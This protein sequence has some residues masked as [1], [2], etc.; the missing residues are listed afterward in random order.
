[1]D[2]TGGSRNIRRTCLV[3]LIAGALTVS[4]AVADDTPSRLRRSESFFGLHF[5]LHACESDVEIGKTLTEGMVQRIIDVARPDYLQ[6]DSKGHEGFCSYPTEVG[7]PAGGFVKDPLRIWRDVTVRNGVALYV[8][9]S[10]LADGEAVAQNPDWG[11][12]DADGTLCKKRP[13]FITSYFGPY[14]DELMIPQLKELNDVYGVDGAWVDGECWAAYHDYS[15]YALKAWKDKTGDAGVPRKSGELHWEE[16][17][18]FCRQG[19]RDYF[20]RYVDAIHAYN[21]DFQIA[22]NWAYS[23]FMPEPVTVGVDFISGD[24]M[25]QNSINSA[26]F[27]GRCLAEQGVAWDLMAWSFRLGARDGYATST[28]TALQLQQEAAMV[29]AL[30]GGFQCYFKQDRFCGIAEWQIQIMGELAAFCRERQEFCHKAELIPQ[31]GLLYSRA[32][33][34]H[35]GNKLFG[36]FKQLQHPAEG[37]LECLLDGQNAVQIVSEHHLADGKISK[38]PV[39]VVPEW[40]YLE[41]KFIEELKTYA[42]NGGQLILIGPGPA[43][44]FE[45][46]LGVALRGEPRDADLYIDRNGHLGGLDTRF[47]PVVPGPQTHVLNRGYIKNDYVGTPEPVVTLHPYGKGQ[48]AGVYVEMG[49]QY[50]LAPTT[51]PRDVISDLVELMMDE[52]LVRVDGSSYVEVVPARKNGKLMVN[53]VNT[54]GPHR[55]DA[56]YDQIPAVGP[57]NVSIR[58]EKAPQSVRLQPGNQPV[59]YQFEDG[60][61]HCAVERLEIHNILEVE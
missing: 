55:G 7:N 30:G 11:L 31:V 56:V 8:H 26:R 38:F 24:F 58:C 37:M 20:A 61:V 51:V 6:C 28:K 32:A 52:P 45:E 35:S 9:Y 22:G 43:A 42:R 14:V 25:P 46:E 3:V 15:P 54:S 41:P 2:S 47:Q 50:K 48:V 17:A 27:Q 10:G 33:L 29:L 12:M 1:M 36:Q 18:E 39:I 16:Y 53:L 13:Y 4:R 19:F 49:R 34:Y 5:D 57:L 44:I 60:I 40:T 23:S 21:P 59:A